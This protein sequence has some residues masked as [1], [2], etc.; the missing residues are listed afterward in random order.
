METGFD[1]ARSALVLVD[2]Q[3]DFLL[4]DGALVRAGASA[5]GRS[6][7]DALLQRCQELIAAARRAGRPV[8]WVKTAVR[9]DFA[10]STLAQSWLQ[11]RRAV[12]REFLVEGSWGAELMDGLSVESDDLVVVKKGHSAFSDT[13]LDRLLTN[14]SVEQCLVAGGGVDDA[15]A[16]TART[17]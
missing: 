5:V 15:I 11:R 8:V 3:R 1:L 17:G 2:L 10:D 13:N 9:R 12:A 14:L 16:E 4:P 6:D 7:V